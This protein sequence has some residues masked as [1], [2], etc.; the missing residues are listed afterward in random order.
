MLDNKFNDKENV[1]HH[2]KHNLL[3]GIYENLRGTQNHFW[4]QGSSSVQHGTQTGR[5]DEGRLRIVHHELKP[6]REVNN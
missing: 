5:Q 1:Y 4:Y 2:L 6:E 3:Q